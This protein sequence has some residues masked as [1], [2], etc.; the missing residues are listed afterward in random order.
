VEL[1]STVVKGQLFKV[2]VQQARF[3]NNTRRIIGSFQFNIAVSVAALILN[4][5]M[6][7]LSILKYV[8]QSLSLADPWR[9]IFDR[10]IGVQSDKVDGLGGDSDMVPA[11]PNDKWLAGPDSQTPSTGALIEM[12]NRCCKRTSLLLIIAILILF[13]LMIFLFIRLD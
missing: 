13:I 4:R 1:P 9:L 12:F 8:R 6:R 5:E 3:Y 2:L 10:Y 11:A 7:N